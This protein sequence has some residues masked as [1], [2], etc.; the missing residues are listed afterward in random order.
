MYRKEWRVANNNK[1]K[2]RAG[3]CTG[4]GK[5]ASQGSNTNKNGLR[6]LI[7]IYRRRRKRSTYRKNESYK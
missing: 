7:Q 1:N 4:K 3:N 6:R 2:G 5:S